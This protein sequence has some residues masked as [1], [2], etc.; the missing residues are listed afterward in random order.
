[1]SPC[2]LVVTVICPDFPIHI[3][4]S[5]NLSANKGPLLGALNCSTVLILLRT[6]HSLEWHE[7]R[8]PKFCEQIF[9]FFNEQFLR[10]I[11]KH[12]PQVLWT[13]LHFFWRTMQL[14]FLYHIRSRQWR[15]INIIYCHLSFYIFWLTN[16]LSVYRGNYSLLINNSNNIIVNF[17]TM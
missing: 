7:N 13:D 2:I 4:T 11:Q 3:E 16:T 17:T 10:V 14:I 9:N 6:R 12:I 8:F 15:I 5:P 1:M